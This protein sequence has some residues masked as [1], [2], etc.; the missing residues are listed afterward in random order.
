MNA[1]TAC[2]SAGDAFATCQEKYMSELSRELVDAMLEL[3]PASEVKHRIRRYTFGKHQ[4]ET[5]EEI[6]A[7]LPH[8]ILGTQLSAHIIGNHVPTLHTKDICSIIE[9][10]SLGFRFPT[11]LL[12]YF[13]KQIDP[14]WLNADARRI[15]QYCL[16]NG[17]RPEFSLLAPRER[18]RRS[19]RMFIRWQSEQLDSLLKLKEHPLFAQFWQSQPPASPVSEKVDTAFL[20]RTS[21]DVLA[22]RA[23]A[24]AQA[25]V[26]FER[27]MN[28]ECRAQAQPY[29][30][31]ALESMRKAAAD[32]KREAYIFFAESGLAYDTIF[33]DDVKSNGR[34]EHYR[35][36]RLLNKPCSRGSVIARGLCLWALE[37]N[38]KFEYIVQR[39]DHTFP[40]KLQ[41]VILW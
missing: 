36:Y 25:Q 24:E 27:D 31:P 5:V 39:T 11:L 12:G 17:L 15:Y 32:G 41:M 8:L 13:S 33:G 20:V 29:I 28:E 1:S 40:Y 35:D 9:E 37:Q 10:S 18:G 26:A 16:D 3:L 2:Y 21:E 19:C 22:A 4:P 34:Y 30:A 14:E 38:F 6:I 7:A 23:V